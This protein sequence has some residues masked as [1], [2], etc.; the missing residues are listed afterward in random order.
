[1]GRKTKNPRPKRTGS[2]RVT[3]F[4]PHL[5]TQIRSAGRSYPR[6]VTGAP[7]AAYFAAAVRCAARG[8]IHVRIPCASHRPAALCPAGRALLVPVIA[9]GIYDNRKVPI[10][11]GKFV[12]YA[13]SPKY[14]RVTST[15]HLS[16]VFTPHIRHPG[17]HRI[18]T[19]RSKG[20]S[21]TR[22]RESAYAGSRPLHACTVF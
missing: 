11:Q 16:A 6:A 12:F 17:L 10:C 9:S 4:I 21:P 18:P 22:D 7:G 19:C 5:L 13:F 8:C 2:T 20:R 3:T 1:M 14:R 15:H